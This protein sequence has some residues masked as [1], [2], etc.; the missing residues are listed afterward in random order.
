MLALVILQTYTAVL[1][2]FDLE[3]F[4]IPGFIRIIF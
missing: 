2:V 3:L 1:F 4:I